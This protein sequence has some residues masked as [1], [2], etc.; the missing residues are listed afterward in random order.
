[1]PREVVIQAPHQLEPFR[2]S[3]LLRS[4]YDTLPSPVN[5]ARWGLREDPLCKLCG[6]KGTLSHILAGCPTAL[7][8]GRYRWRHDQVICVIADILE[9]ARRKPQPPKHQ[10]SSVQFIRAGEQMPSVKRGR[11]SNILQ[12]HKDGR[13]QQTRVGSSFSPHRPDHP[14]A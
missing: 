2:V 10:V 11:T 9:Q 5:L 7:A 8:Q 1:M 13:C 12:G 6:K 3:F 4:V 14:E